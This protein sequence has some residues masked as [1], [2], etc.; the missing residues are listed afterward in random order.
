M[1][2]FILILMLMAAVQ[3]VGQDLRADLALV[4]AEAV[5]KE[6][7]K[8]EKISFIKGIFKVYSNHIS[9]QSTSPA[10]KKKFNCENLRK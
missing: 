7:V 3:A 6:E 8:E 10:S 9:D 4:K 2:N 1:R 5:H